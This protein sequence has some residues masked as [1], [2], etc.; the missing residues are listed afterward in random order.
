[1]ANEILSTTVQAI[2]IGEVEN[3]N[4]DG[5]ILDSDKLEIN[6]IEQLEYYQAA[7]D[8]LDGDVWDEV[9]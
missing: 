5:T 3:I 8:T 4:G 2:S 6:K 7:T 1:M 9:V